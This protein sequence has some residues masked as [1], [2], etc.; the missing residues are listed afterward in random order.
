MTPHVRRYPLGP[1][2]T[3]DGQV[4]L[5]VWAPDHESVELVLSDEH[6]AMAADGDGYFRATVPARAGH[7]YGFR[8][9]GDDRIYPDPA[10]HWQPEGPE[11]LSALVDLRYSWTDAAWT[12]LTWRGQVLYELHVGTFTA[13]GTWAAAA[14]ELPRLKS[15]GITAIQMMP[16]AEFAGRFGWGYDGV[17]WY[18][19]IHAYGT[20]ADLQQFIDR[21]HAL[22]LGVILDVVYNH[23]GPAGNFLPRFARSCVANRNRTEWGEGL[24]F[25]SPCAGGVR[26]LVLG[27]VAYW[28]REFHI[29]GFR[30][31]AAHALVDESP[32]HIVAAITRVARAT[33]APRGAIIIAE[34]EPQR[35]QLLRGVAAGGMG[36]DGVFNEDLHHSTRVALTGVRDGY[37]SDYH[38]T[39]QEW[40]A[41][42]RFGFLFQGQ[43]YRWQSHRRGAPALDIPARHFVAFLENH[44]QVANSS[45]GQRLATLTSPAWW[46][47]LSALLVLGPWTP[48]L[49]QGQEWGATAPFRYF[50]DHADDL[51]QAVA[52]GR[53]TFLNQFPRMQA[54]A[55]LPAVG[56]EAFAAST[57]GP[58]PAAGTPL[59]RLYHDLLT[60]RR[61]DGTLGVGAVRLE[62]ATLGDRTLALRYIGAEPAHD[63]LL[64]VNLAPDRD[65]AG[66]PDPLFAPVSPQGWR[67]HWCSED[68]R[69]GGGGYPPVVTDHALIAAGH[70]TTVFAPG[71]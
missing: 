71:A 13:A 6:H 60:L 41:A 24:D 36:L 52:D 27:N 62:G 66:I 5:R 61:E 59:V 25:D 50:A 54:T 46:R 2:W 68:V 31:D 10:S 28:V 18:A 39:S 9:P 11:A 33:A 51:Q 70:A 26:D 49:F 57:L 38:G 29:D 45:T 14:G 8:L 55:A 32:E 40:L 1:E 3:P 12:G 67:V 35:A 37:L 65:I 21:A 53:R 34:D 47:A 22:G 20:P 63:R 15:M 58:P 48:L 19:P 4:D 30:I 64:L 43:Y 69:Y 16:V 42:A 56:Q 17:Q 7:R 44:D 23:L